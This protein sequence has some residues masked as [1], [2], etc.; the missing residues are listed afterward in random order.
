[1]KKLMTVLGLLI[2]AS[3]IL[4]ACAQATPAATE[5]PAAATAAPAATEAPT[6]VPATTRTG[7]W[8]DEVD[9]SA[10]PDCASAIPQLQ[11]GA[12][13][14]FFETCSEAENYAIAKADPNMT[15]TTST[16]LSFQLMPNVV[17]CADT[18][19]LNPFTSAK[20]RE[21]M[22]WMIDRNYIAQEILGGLGTARYTLLDTYAPDYARYATA[23]GKIIA[24]YGYNMEK[25]QAVVDSE[26][27]AFGA[28]KGAD[29]KWQ[30]KGKP[31]TIPVLIRTEDSRKAIGDYFSNQLE[32]LGFTVD[33][34]Y[35]PRK[36]A[37][38]IW[39]A[40][41][42]DL[43]KCQFMVY[44]AGWGA[45]AISRDEG[46]MFAQYNTDKMQAIPLFS[47][48]KPSDAYYPVLQKLFTNDFNTMDERDALF[49]QALPMSMTESWHGAYVVDVNAF[50]MFSNKWAIASD[51]AAGIGN[52]A[53]WPFTLR[54]TG[55]EGGV[56]KIGQFGLLT[57]FW[58][59]VTG[60]NW[61]DDGAPQRGTEDWGTMF[62]PYTG[63]ALPQRIESATVTALKGLPITKNLDWDNLEFVD[64]I[65]V[66][67]ECWADWD[68]V[69][70][71]WIT[72]AEK[73]ASDPNWKATAKVKSTAVYP[74]SL[75]DTKWHDGSNFSA[76]DVVMYMIATFDLGKPDSKDFNSEYQP[77]LDSL[78]THF[79][80][81]CI[82]STNPLT[83][84]TYD[85]AYALDAENNVISWYPSGTTG[86]AYS[87]GTAG[88]H[89]ITPALLAEADGKIAMS[90]T[91]ADAKKVDP[92]SMISGPTLEIQKQYLDKAATDKYIPYANV[93]GQYIT[94]DEAAARYANLQKFY[95]DH[96]HL[97]IGTG[98]L[99]IDK[100]YPTES[101]MVLKY[102]ADFPDKSDKWAN[103]STAR[104]AVATIDGPSTVTIGQPA[105]FNV[106]ITFQDAPYP[107]ADLNGV[108]YLVKDANGE[109]NVEGNATLTEDGK[110]V[111]E[112]TA[113]QTAKL[114]AGSSVLSV[115]VSS[116]V[117]ALPTFVNYEFVTVAP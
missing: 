105:T 27:T 66:P 6:P 46:N 71:K 41:P 63:L 107:M 60:S 58:N 59:P 10:I 106:T 14:L 4:T 5:A 45:T 42:E 11:A 109:I 80:G 53:F 48:Y 79:K 29:G 37:G 26:M 55:E 113:D 52:N 102:F 32:K 57:Q 25:A 28:T 117:V 86:Y 19:V 21:A 17:A 103:F 84:D 43:A 64:S 54:K 33:R 97:W 36:D 112:L 65:T 91:D 70:Q 2:A 39:Q 35:K 104:V 83:I 101:Q 87:F 73:A 96:G 94:A 93:L 108:S 72:V 30:Y 12:I 40:G 62:D 50:N 34:Q 77:T 74:A 81:V 13:D 23:I 20:M 110:A 99:Y 31:V 8:V 24:Q 95:A 16:G 90:Q 56:A 3:M 100:V 115:A 82:T 116:K 85:D 51:L 69:N 61:V 89:N 47:E 22:N 88:W 44:T 68:A 7:A 76:A 67:G 38:P 49:N 1:M 78:L 18:N 111:I 98:P 75:F 92:T 114:V 15:T 9:F